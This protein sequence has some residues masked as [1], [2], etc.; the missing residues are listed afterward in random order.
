M[1]MAVAS[2]NFNDIFRWRRCHS[3]S[4]FCRPTDRHSSP[5]CEKRKPVGAGAGRVRAV[6]AVS[7][8]AKRSAE[9]MTAL[10]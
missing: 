4:L 10:K 8:W 3:F 1:Q 7:D 6:R 5:T 9:P 2:V